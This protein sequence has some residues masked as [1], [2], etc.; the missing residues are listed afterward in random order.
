M[1]I[2]LNNDQILGS[3]KLERWWKSR[4]KQTI[5]VGGKA[6]CGKTTFILYFIDRIGLPLD[7]VLFV[8]YMG[9]AVSRMIQTGL[10]AKTLHSTCYTYE[11]EPARGEDGKIIYGLNGKPK[12]VWVPIL[13]DHLPKKIKLIVADEA[14]TI[15]EKNGKDLE[16][17][18]IPIIAVGDPHQLAPPFGKAYFLT[19]DNLDITLNQIMRQAEG[20]PII[21]L[22]Q[23]ALDRLPIPEGAYGSSTVIKKANLTDYALKKADIILTTTNRLRGRV[24]DLFRENFMNVGNLDIP[25]VGE[26]VIC[27]A[28]D[29]S[30]FIPL[31]GTECYLTNGTTGFI[32]YVDTRS[33]TTKSI[34]MDFMPDYGKRPF[35]SL[36]ADLQRLNAPL[37]VNK[38]A[39][40]TPP[41]MNV[42]E[43]GYALTTM[44]SQGSEWN[45]VLI[46]DEGVIFSVDTYYRG[47]YV[48]LTRARDRVTLVR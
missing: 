30:K 23:R 20:N 39:A 5:S 2:E 41:D 44:S 28:N 31:G 47:L 26:K 48:A 42:F 9:K 19:G 12:M 11:K 15:P 27:R 24:N 4:Y 43:Y 45:D 46:M 14:Y 3:C 10:P 40:W 1:G 17:F 34:K 18:G 16:S 13:K 7:E 8:S 22:A 38:D 37:G 29:W 32:D 36:K 21:Y 6:G 35:R 33:Y 25:H